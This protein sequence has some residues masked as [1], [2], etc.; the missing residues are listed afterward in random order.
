MLPD[1]VSN[2]GP[3]TYESGSL[4][5]ALRGPALGDGAG[6]LTVAGRP[7]SLAVSGARDY[8]ACS[9]CKWGR[10]D[11][12]LS[13]IISLFFLPLFGRRF[14]I[15]NQSQRIIEPKSTENQPTSKI[16]HRNLKISSE[17]DKFFA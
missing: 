15:N 11:I 4:P 8:W 2:P 1:R 14:D 9:R 6:Q 5:T 12:F 17:A 3:L 16:N 13:S 10:L 7:I